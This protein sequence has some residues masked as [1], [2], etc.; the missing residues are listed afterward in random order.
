[1]SQ[2]NAA[3]RTGAPAQSGKL[4]RLRLSSFG[5][6]TMLIL[7]F[8]LGSV[9]SL[10]GTAPTAHK[11][12][13]LF[14][15]PDLALHVILAILLVLTAVMQLIRAVGIRHRLALVL[16]AAGLAA[17]IGAGFAGLGY[18]GSGANGASLGMALLFAVALACYAVLVLVLPAR[19]AGAAGAAGDSTT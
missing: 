1:M 13:G 14:S 6:V 16:S 18:T 12:I 4:A 15:S 10:Y 17:I 19:P 2:T 7:E 11:S 9:Y 8:I 5:L 3:R